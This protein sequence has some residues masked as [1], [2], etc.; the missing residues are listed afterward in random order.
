MR[1]MNRRGAIGQDLGNVNLFNGLGAVE[2]GERAG[3]F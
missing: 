3:D 2:I 1:P